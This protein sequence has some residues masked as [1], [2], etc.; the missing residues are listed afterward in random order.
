VLSRNNRDLTRRF[1]SVRDSLLALSAHG[2]HR[3]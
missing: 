2:P 3:W 1:R